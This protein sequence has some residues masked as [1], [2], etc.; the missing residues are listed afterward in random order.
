MQSLIGTDTGDAIYDYEVIQNRMY[1]HP[2]VTIL[3]I[4]NFKESNIFIR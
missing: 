2:Y 4:I 3:F 1:W